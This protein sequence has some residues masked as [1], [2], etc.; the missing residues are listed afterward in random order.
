MLIQNEASIH[1]TYVSGKIQYQNAVDTFMYIIL[2]LLYI[3]INIKKPGA[4]VSTNQNRLGTGIGTDMVPMEQMW[5]RWKMYFKDTDIV[6]RFRSAALHRIQ[7]RLKEIAGQ[8]PPALA[9]RKQS[10]ASGL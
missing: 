8:P 4:T 9:K 10:S 3:H 2:L 7:L 6:C 5:F 1:N